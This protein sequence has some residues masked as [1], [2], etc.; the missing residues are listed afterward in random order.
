MNRLLEPKR[1][2]SSFSF[3]AMNSLAGKS[4]GFMVLASI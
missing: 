1:T 2:L 4:L 3:F